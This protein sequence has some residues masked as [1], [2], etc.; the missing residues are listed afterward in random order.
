ME[1]EIQENEQVKI[2]LE[3][4]EYGQDSRNLEA[5]LDKIHLQLVKACAARRARKNWA[6]LS[7]NIF[8]LEYL[9]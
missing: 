2:E 9:R 8:I 5:K 1:Q 6:W 3:H 4:G 7:N